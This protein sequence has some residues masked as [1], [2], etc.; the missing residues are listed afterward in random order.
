MGDAFVLVVLEVDVDA[1][2][3]CDFHVRDDVREDAKEDLHVGGWEGVRQGVCV[4][5]ECE[6]PILAPVFAKS[7][8]VF[9]LSRPDEKTFMKR[10]YARY[11]YSPNL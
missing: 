10:I 5:V 1:V 3:L 2:R 6:L 11:I 4:V 8:F 9:Q 7:N